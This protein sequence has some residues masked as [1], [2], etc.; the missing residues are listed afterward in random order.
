M[1]S[2]HFKYTMYIEKQGERGREGEREK[3]WMELDLH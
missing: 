3:R 2:F 1:F